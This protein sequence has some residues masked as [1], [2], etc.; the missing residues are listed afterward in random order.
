MKIF[1][2]K[3][4]IV[5]P[6]I[7]CLITS[8]ALSGCSKKSD[9]ILTVHHDVKSYNLRGNE[10]YY[11]GDYIGA[12]QNYDRA[13][14]LAR[15]IDDV[16]GEAESL[17]NL[18]QLYLIASDTKAARKKFDEAFELNESIKNEKGMAANLNNI[19][20][21]YMQMADFT[22]AKQYLVDASAIYKKL[23]ISI[24]LANV[25]NNL[26]L[27]EMEFG[28]F[29]QA[30]KHFDAA[31]KVAKERK[32]HRLA[33][34]CLQNMGSLNERRG[35]FK[36]ALASYK[37]ALSRDKLV[38]YSVG[39][40][41]DLSDI[42]RMEFKLGMVSKATDSMERSLFINTQLGFEKKMKSNLIVLIDYAKVSGDRKARKVYEVKLRKLKTGR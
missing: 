35:D 25:T 37:Q 12:A 20:S 4:L 36:K 24:A 17:N 18:G 39:I 13:R 22:R 10:L 1:S 21:I 33:A 32:R 34:A 6:V 16:G 31:F 30:S 9:I 23:Q 2:S 42:S 29:D 5:V 28:N 40:A 3:Q 15:G 7:L 11:K 26:G 19:G 38:E 8:C 41:D 27:L 14:V